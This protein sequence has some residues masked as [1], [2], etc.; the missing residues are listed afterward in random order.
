MRRDKTAEEAYADRMAEARSML[1]SLADRLDRHAAKAAARPD[2]W[3]LVGD[4]TETLEHLDE[5]IRMVGWRD[6]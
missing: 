6:R 1:A 3:C 5:A 4:L 2:D